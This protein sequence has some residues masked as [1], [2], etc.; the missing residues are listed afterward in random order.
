MMDKKII[1]ILCSKCCLFGPVI[2]YWKLFFVRCSR[3][4]LTPLGYLWRRDQEELLD[5]MIQCG[6][7][8][9]IIKVATLG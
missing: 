8:A 3:L 4:G 7:K 6:I 9:I 5:E 1:T 2:V